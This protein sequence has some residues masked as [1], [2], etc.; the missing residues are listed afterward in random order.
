MEVGCNEQNLKW[1][2]FNKYKHKKTCQITS[3][4]SKNSQ[5]NNGMI[6]RGTLMPT[7][8]NERSISC[9]YTLEQRQSQT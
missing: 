3:I 2:G 5:K 6:Q 7:K 8:D 9:K 1:Q 4:T